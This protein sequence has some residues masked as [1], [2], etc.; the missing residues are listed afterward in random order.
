MLDLDHVQRATSFD[1]ELEPATQ[2]LLSLSERGITFL[3]LREL[4]TFR[5]ECFG[6]P[7]VYALSI[8][9]CVSGSLLRTV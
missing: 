8:L 5:I 7:A 3:E 1:S 9:E 2:V 6:W 4:F